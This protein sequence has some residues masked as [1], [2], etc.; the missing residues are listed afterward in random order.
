MLKQIHSNFN[1][2]ILSELWKNK[3]VYLRTE[4]NSTVSKM[5]YLFVTGGLGNIFDCQEIW[6]N[7]I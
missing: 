1:P 2:L 3:G 6:W 4:M 7:V 5:R